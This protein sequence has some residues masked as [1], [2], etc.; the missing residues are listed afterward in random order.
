VGATADN[1]QNADRAIASFRNLQVK[2]RVLFLA[3]EPLL[4][5]IEFPKSSYESGESVPSPLKM[6]N[7]IYIGGKMNTLE[8]EGLI[9]ESEWIGSLVH[10]ATEEKVDVY[11]NK[12]AESMVKKL[13]N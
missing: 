9:P 13:P 8:A 7:W 4:E 2:P 12:S 6:L 11:L 5:R 10:Q 3:F 1:Q